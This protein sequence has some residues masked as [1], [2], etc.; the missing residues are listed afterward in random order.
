MNKILNR[1]YGYVL[2]LLELKPLFVLNR[3]FK[4]CFIGDKDYP[5]LDN[6]VFLLYEFTGHTWFLEF[7]TKLKDHDQFITGYE[8]D[9]KHSMYVY[10]IP[11]KY[12]DDLALLKQS[13]Y[14]QIK[15]SA[16]QQILSF[17]QEVY[18][19]SVK[20]LENVLYK[21]EDS[22]LSWEKVIN[23]GLP[24]GRWTTIPRDMEASPLMDMDIEV[25]SDKY[26]EVTVLNGGL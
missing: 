9:K 19:E 24:R 15:D 22:Y 20:T 25:Y 18:P 11:E 13:K 26:K 7:E 6:H 8:P 16:K 3:Q 23:Q 5:E 10:E 12:K 21:K 14:S 17:Y 4:G 1:S 2:P